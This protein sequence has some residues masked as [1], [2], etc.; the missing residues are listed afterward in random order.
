[1]Q[2]VSLDAEYIM[3]RGKNAALEIGTEDAPFTHKATITLHGRRDTAK[4]IPVYGAK[5]IAVRFGTL[6]LH[7]LPKTPTWTRL[8]VTAKAGDQSVRSFPPVLP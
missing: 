6:D 8:G 3:V 1:M 2:D 5:N 7:G 4:E